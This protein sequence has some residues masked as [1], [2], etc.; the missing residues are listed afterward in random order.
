[1]LMQINK[2]TFCVA[3]VRVCV[4]SLGWSGYGVS[5]DTHLGGTNIIQ[6]QTSAIDLLERLISEMTCN[7]LM[8]TLN[9][10]HSFTLTT[11]TVIPANDW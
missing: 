7:M 4:L 9:P 11:L 1:M 2:A 6:I 8:G 5:C 10:T 3:L